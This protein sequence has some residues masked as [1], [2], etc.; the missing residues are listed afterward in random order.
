VP[1]E[2]SLVESHSENCAKEP[3]SLGI[4]TG[5]RCEPPSLITQKSPPQPDLS[6]LLT[7]HLISDVLPTTIYPD[8]SQG[9]SLQ[10]DL[11]RG[12][13][14]GPFYID[15]SFSTSSPSAFFYSEVPPFCYPSNFNADQIIPDF[16]HDHTINDSGL[17]HYRNNIRGLFDNNGILDEDTPRLNL[18][19]FECTIP[20]LRPEPGHIMNDFGLST[21]HASW[22]ITIED[23]QEFLLKMSDFNSVIPSG[24]VLPS[25]HT[26]SRYLGCYVSSFHSHL[27]FLHVPTMEIKNSSPELVLA[28]AAVGGQYC[29]D[30]AK[31]VELFKASRAIVLERIRRKGEMKRTDAKEES[32]GLRPLRAAIPTAANGNPLNTSERDIPAALCMP[33]IEFDPLETR[34]TLLLLMAMATW[35]GNKAM[36]TEALAIQSTL[37]S[38][39]RED[40]L[41][42]LENLPASATWEDWIWLERK[43][44]TNF[45]IYIFFNFH[46]IIYNTAP[47]ILNTELYTELPCSETE[48]KCTTADAWKYVRCVSGPEP[49]FQESLLSL[50]VKKESPK[51]TSQCSSL[52]G[53][54]LIHALIQQIFLVRQASRY[55]P[56]SDGSLL[57][58]EISALEQALANWKRIWDRN[59]ES[60]LDPKNPHG[61]LAFTST[62]LLTIAYIR[63]QVDTGPWR[64]LATQDPQQIARTM[65]SSPSIQRSSK[66]TQAALHS[67]QALSIPIRLGINLIS[68]NQISTWSLQH[69]VCSLEYAVLL[70]KW[71]DAVTRQLPT[72]HALTE[73]EQL[74]LDFVVNMLMESDYDRQSV[75]SGTEDTEEGGDKP[76]FTALSARVVEVW[77]RMFSGDAIWGV[78][79]MIG[80]AMCAYGEMLERSDSC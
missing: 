22:N 26:L 58:Q 19:Q 29:F 54:I 48:W 14:E 12:N 37:V 23:R 42:N 38:I 9:T 40:G 49:S 76:A 64:S 63:L 51:P 79:S 15:M 43:K 52:G 65:L 77:A 50:F 13:V 67:A 45:I 32:S 27:P 4:S 30:H 66:V 56:S 61:P 53:Y 24:F 72:G 31:G 16:W 71:L 36:Y 35:S 5:R 11:S 60:S 18:P 75:V 25:C 57:A 17:L 20:P 73:D 74:L 46:S 28:I 8:L 59:P 33:N 6:P 70:S 80:K 34:Q 41:L 78:V 69:S 62:A 1:L 44:R 55:R 3:S 39:I 47:A 68:R 7:G 21:P 2:E 10:G